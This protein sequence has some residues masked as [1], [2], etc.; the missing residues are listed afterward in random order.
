[1]IQLLIRFCFIVSFLC[2]ASSQ[3]NG[4]NSESEDSENS[5]RGGSKSGTIFNH[6]LT[7]LPGYSED[8][9]TS[10]YFPQHSDMKIP[11]GEYVPLLCHFANDGENALNVTAIMASLNSP[12]EFHFFVQNFTYKPFGVVVKGGEEITFE[13]LFQLHPALEPADFTLA[14]TV[15]Y[16]SDTISYSSTFFNQVASCFTK[17]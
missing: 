10:Y 17:L 1:M 8:V 13:Y 9:V 3:D 15:F 6:P 7:D 12:Y 16:E 5:A 11:I 4:R 2:L 14:A